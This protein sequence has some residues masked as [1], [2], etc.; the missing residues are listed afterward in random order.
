MMVNETNV[1]LPFYKIKENRTDLKRKMMEQFKK[2]YA[3]LTNGTFASRINRVE[4]NS[5]DLPFTVKYTHKSLNILVR[6]EKL[7]P[8]YWRF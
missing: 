3:K 2:L 1:Y 4:V 6:S 8:K 7:W 5:F